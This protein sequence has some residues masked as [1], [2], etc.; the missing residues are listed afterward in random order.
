MIVDTSALVAIVVDEPRASALLDVLVELE[1]PLAVGAPT[2]LEAGMVLTARIGPHGRLFLDQLLHEFEAQTVGFDVEHW[3]L[4]L[5]AFSR[6]GK[7][8]HS[9]ALNFGDCLT[10][11]VARQADEPLL[12]VGDDFPQTDLRIVEY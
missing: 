5:S 11:A 7:G 3:S 10:Y 6:F 4:A 2:L 8:R 1:T 9:A 12:C